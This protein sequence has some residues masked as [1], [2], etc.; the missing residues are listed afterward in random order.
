MFPSDATIALGL[1]IT[2]ALAIVD[3]YVWRSGPILPHP[4]AKPGPSDAGDDESAGFEEV[5]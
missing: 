1:V 3:W 4:L 2:A 5:A